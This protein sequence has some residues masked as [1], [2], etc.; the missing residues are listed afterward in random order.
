V[1]QR[2][3]F[4][5]LVSEYQTMVARIC[6]SYE[7]DR[8]LCRDLSQEVW[9][10]IWREW[11]AMKTRW[12][13][14]SVAEILMTQQLRWGLRLRMLGS[15]T[16]LSLEILGFLLVGALGIVQLAMGRTVLGL[17]FI[18]LVLVCAGAS[19]WARRATLRGASGSL[20]ELVD[21]A[22]RRARRGV[23]MAWANYF[24]TAVTAASILALFA[25][26]IGPAD[27]AH[28]DEGRVAFAMVTLAL[29]ALGVGVYHVYARRR[30]RRFAAMRG[31][32]NP[33]GEE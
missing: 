4:E 9:F 31:Q 12:Q 13:S 10:A 3:R 7:R 26:D 21:L 23:R 2:P 28:H 8:D 6:A 5:E 30:V 19:V 1:S 33:R 11:K 32:L 25:S 20:A 18:G 22:L 24:M 29:Y 15:W 14:T 17:V 27:A 16:W